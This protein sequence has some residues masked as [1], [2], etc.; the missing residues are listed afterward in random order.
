VNNDFLD[1]THLAEGT[2]HTDVTGNRGRD[3][4]WD[5]PASRRS[6]KRTFYANWTAT[7]GATTTPAAAAIAGR[8]TASA[9]SMS[10]A[11]PPAKTAEEHVPL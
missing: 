3:N 7:T 1:G 2:G 8:P 4:G 11:S 9:P 6:A 10:R 5:P